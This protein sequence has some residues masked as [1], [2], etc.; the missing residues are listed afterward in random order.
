MRLFLRWSSLFLL[1]WGG[2]N[3]QDVPPVAAYRPRA[4]NAKEASRPQARE[5]KRL[6]AVEM[7]T[8]LF[9]KP[10]ARRFAGRGD[11]K[12]LRV[13]F[14]LFDGAARTVSF[15]QSEVSKD[16]R[17]ASWT[18][19]IEGDQY[20]SAVL[21]HHDD[22]ISSHL[23]LGDGRVFEVVTRDG[24]TYLQ[25]FD[26]SS[27]RETANDAL[28]SGLPPIF[29]IADT[30]VADDGN[31]ID[32]M[33][34]YTAAARAAVGGEAQMQALVREGVAL[35]NQAY[36]NSAIDQRLRLAYAGEIDYA[37]SGSMSTDLDRLTG[38]TDG[39]MDNVHQLR[40]Q[41]GADFVSLWI[42][43]SDDSAGLGWLNTTQSTAFA[44]R[45]FNVCD[46]RA[47]VSNLTFPHEL[48]HNMGS[49]H[50][51]DNSSGA[52]LFPYSY[53]FQQAA[54]APFYRTVMAY[55]CSAGV[56]CPRLPY[57]SNPDV[58][59]AGTA[60]GVEATASRSAD[61]RRTFNEGV[62]WT[63]NFRS[64]SNAP[65]PTLSIAPSRFNAT[66]AGGSAGVDVTATG[67]WA[68]QNRLSW[69]RITSGE[70]GSGN[71]RVEFTVAPNTQTISRSGTFS[72]G[73]ESVAILQAAD[74]T[75]TCTLLS[76]TA[77][78]PV[79]GMLAENGCVS[80]LRSN[81]Y[82][83]RY[84]FNG[85]QGQQIA[86]AATSGDLDPY[87]YLVSP[88]GAVLQENDDSGGSTNARVPATSGF[89]TLPVSGLYT[90][91]VSTF[92]PRATGN[93]N[94][95]VTTNT[96]ACTY[97]LNPASA[98]AGAGQGQGVVN[99]TTQ[100]GCVV[101]AVSNAPWILIRSA[102]E[103]SG[104]ST[105]A[106]EVR[107][108]TGASRTGN[109]TI[110]GRQFTLT[111][112]GQPT[113]CAVT[114]IAP[115][116]S[117]NGNLTA[118][119][120]LGQFRQGTFY[121]ARYRLSGTAGQRVQITLTSPTLDTYMYL[122]G[123]DGRVVA[124]DDDA[125]G[126]LNSRIPTTGEYFG[127][128]STGDYI[129]E[130]TSFDQRAAGAITLAVTE[131]GAG[132]AVSGVLVPGQPYLVSLPPA[133]QNTLFDD[134]V[135]E[136]TVPEGARR[137]E[138]RTEPSEAGHDIDLFVRYG[139]P[140][141]I[142][143]QNVVSDHRSQGETGAE[144]IVIDAVS[145]PALRAGKYY[146]ALAQFTHNVASDVNV[147]ATVD[148][149]PRSS[150]TLRERVISRTAPSGCTTPA[151]AETFAP[152]DAR[153]H[154][155]FIGEGNQNGVAR[156]EFIDPQGVRQANVAFEPQPEAGVY[157]RTASL[158]I[159]STPNA[160]R[161]GRW[162]V[163]ALWDDAEITTATFV[164][165]ASTAAPP[166]GTFPVLVSGRAQSFS[167]QAVTVPSLLSRDGTYQIT[168]PADATRME[169]RL[170]TTVPA[171]ADL[172]L[173]VNFGQPST[174]AN[175]SVVADHSAASA[176]GNEIIVID[177]NSSPPLRAGTYYVTLALYSTGVN[178]Q[179]SVTATFQTPGAFTVR[180]R[181]MSRT[182]AT[183]CA[184][185]A[186]ADTFLAADPRAVLFF[187]GTG[188]R[189]GIASVQFVD[190]SGTVQRNVTFEP[191]SVDGAGCFN[192]TLDIAGTANA[193]RL[194]RW[195]ARAFW[196][197][198]ELFALNFTIAASGPSTDFPVLSPG[199][200]LTFNFAPVTS[201]SFAGTYILNVPAG[202]TRLDVSLVTTT[203]NVDIDVYV[204]Y[205]QPPTGTTFDH[206]GDSVT[207]SE[208]VS[209]TSGST[210]PLR[211]GTY[212][213]SLAVFTPNI[214]ST[215]TLRATLSATG[216]E[217]LLEKLP[218]PISDQ[219]EP[220]AIRKDTASLRQDRGPIR[221]R[222]EALPPSSAKPD[223]TK[224]KSHVPR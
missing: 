35:S 103:T 93:F 183:A 11:L 98:Q 118:T 224:T 53:G 96:A 198:S 159:A 172:D 39:H 79:A 75:V 60:T 145:Q 123:P 71:G 30:A 140:P 31:V 204:R 148:T 192:A 168:V 95:S 134:R 152:T 22:V 142:A 19:S 157:C 85:V 201:A 180:E 86:V 197:G 97:T 36:A 149:A 41:Y 34:V 63:A 219:A 205:G 173:Y 211:A 113:G 81:S 100:A 82:A 139:A 137:L 194:G 1:A 176:S 169:I 167:F 206:L 27:I 119:S 164:I 203:P 111:Q 131:A 217:P 16:G 135:L 65:T 196:N 78:S 221:S 144:R 24:G 181:I 4:A 57:F 2:L 18:G 161:L 124:E 49:N 218:Q 143:D 77:G 21:V 154:L 126:N 101:T 208:F 112:A 48:G 59:Y 215:G 155:Y 116:Q 165:Q 120:C 202:F 189:G 170:A 108:N 12:P 29:P 133:E 216:D 13:L 20:G 61:N 3:A 125:A 175:G 106:Y 33:V 151:A 128:P 102:G 64:Q 26:P 186:A 32:V 56:N 136:I 121:A 147:I 8:D 94:V 66:A 55:A 209:I 14:P 58:R 92:A 222:L 38:L 7:N 129:I 193:Q 105:V 62:R 132:P 163:R 138:I 73:T 130:A 43:R 199:P 214:R 212:Y 117:L 178:V 127:L 160:T 150:F 88:D 141:A 122:I 107:P 207:G 91:E 89:F 187:V 47:A 84:V 114:P 90:I 153:A 210:P 110:G 156:V 200:A 46:R 42:S 54:T 5:V 45:A 174:V 213:I 185:P 104:N 115:G 69:V 158:P 67:A 17:T 162:T 195:T 52:P 25:E 80:A 190:P 191:Y 70:S 76:I 220:L 188:T 23:F 44:R 50:D 109:I 223:K 72:I 9:D 177:R 83:A 15:R 51:R 166:T 74:E 37:E 184:T 10:H 146:V 40:D 28:E 87:L 171:N 68:V 6:Q 179:G 99:V 182:A